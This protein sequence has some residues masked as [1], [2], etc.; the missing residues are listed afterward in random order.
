MLPLI[1][2]KVYALNLLIIY[3]Q[4]NYPSAST[5]LSKIILAISATAAVTSNVRLFA[6][7]CKVLPGHLGVCRLEECSQCKRAFHAI[8]AGSTEDFE[9]TG[10]CG[11]SQCS[12]I[13][14]AAR[15]AADMTG[16]EVQAAV[17]AIAVSVTGDSSPGSSQRSALSQ[18]RRPRP[19]LDMLKL[20]ISVFTDTLIEI[21]FSKLLICTRY[22][23][24]VIFLCSL[25]LIYSMYQLAGYRMVHYDI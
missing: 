15:S 9:Q 17:P 22:N 13:T 10:R 8:C 20:P 11:Q 21:P 25:L 3:Q 4:Y 16:Q 24:F 6:E 23:F 2:A 7:G 1:P 12:I 14:K 18:P 5:Y 19:T